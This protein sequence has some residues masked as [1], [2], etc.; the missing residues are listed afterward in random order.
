MLKIKFKTFKPIPH[1]DSID[2]FCKQH[3]I[4]KDQFFGKEKISGYLYLRSLT[5]IPEGF[6][7]TV[8]GYLY[9]R[10]LTSIPEGFNPTVGG[11]LDLGSL[12]SIPEGFNPTVGGDLDLG[13][14]TSIPDGFNPT[15]GGGLYLRSLTSIPEG[16]N[17]TVGGDLYWKNNRR[18]IGASVPEINIPEL[19]WKDGKYTK[20]DGIFCEIVSAHAIPGDTTVIQ[21]KKLNK[22]EFFFIARQSGFS[23]HGKTMQLAIEDLKFK[24]IAEKLKKDPINKDTEITVMYYRT[25]TGACDFGCRE[26]MQHNNIPF[27]VE[28]DK[29]VEVSPMKAVDLLPILEKSNAYGIDRFKK[30]ITW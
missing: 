18:Y 14:L 28:N 17:P 26:F 3:N 19:T 8:G 25:L 12:T 20:I 16:F 21:A 5:S 10:S 30:L 24:V 1:M 7:P 4:T 2:K 13:S 27:K 29:T 11:D 22:D 23:A 6:N 9:L 15:V